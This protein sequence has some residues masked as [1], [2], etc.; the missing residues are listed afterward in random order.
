MS[1]SSPILFYVGAAAAAAYILYT[2]P[3][4]PQRVNFYKPNYDFKTY[5]PTLVISNYD[6]RTNS[7]ARDA[8]WLNQYTRTDHRIS[9]PPEY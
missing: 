7:H 1:E 2:K 8:F 6:Y 4:V 3:P 5:D 9:A